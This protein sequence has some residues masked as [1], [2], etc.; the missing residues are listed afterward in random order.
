MGDVSF[1]LVQ[2]LSHSETKHFFWGKKKQ[3]FIWLRYLPGMLS[4]DN[5]FFLC[6]ATYLIFWMWNNFKAEQIV[7]SFQFVVVEKDIVNF[8]L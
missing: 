1:G 3:L 5:S 8:W 4:L 7:S 2:F 6:A